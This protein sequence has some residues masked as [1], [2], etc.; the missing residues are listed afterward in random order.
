MPGGRVG[1]VD[2]AGAV[3]AALGAALAAPHVRPADL[4][5]GGAD[6][7]CADAPSQ[8]RQVRR[9]GHR[10]AMVVMVALL[11]LG[12]VVGVVLLVVLVVVAGNR[13]R[14]RRRAGVGGAAVAV[15]AAVGGAATGRWRRDR[16]R[17]RDAAEIDEGAGRHAVVIGGDVDLD[18]GHPVVFERGGDGEGAPVAERQRIV[19]GLGCGHGR[20]V[21]HQIPQP[22]VDG[23]SLADRGLRD[24]ELQATQRQLAAEEGGAL[25]DHLAGCCRIGGGDDAP[26]ARHLHGG[27]VGGGLPSGRPGRGITRQ[28]GRGRDRDRV[29]GGQ[30]Q[31]ALG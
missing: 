5:G 12:L 6:D 23:W 29:I 19:P 18:A 24:R 15:A 25:D 4:L 21:D 31:H 27:C 26:R 28:L 17:E 30:D 7:V 22:Q 20:S 1:V 9:V 11:G 3:E 10:H 16:S 13:G 14:S 2:E 8:L